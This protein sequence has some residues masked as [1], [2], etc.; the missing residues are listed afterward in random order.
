[1]EKL[2]PKTDGASVDIVG[3]NIERLK[4]L[5]PEVFTEGKI[6]F[7]AL[8]EALGGYL[9]NRPETYSFTWNGKKE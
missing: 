6:D 9:D 1:M 3:Q 4:E 8:R 7:D 2:D 5:F